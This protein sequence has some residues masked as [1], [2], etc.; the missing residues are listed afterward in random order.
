MSEL[1]NAPHDDS[2]RDPAWP[3]AR[4]PGEERTGDPGPGG[5]TA[6]ADDGSA[7]ADEAGPDHGHR[8]PYQPL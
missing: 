2:D 6:G 8:D 4:R 3:P 7:P 5:P 1:R